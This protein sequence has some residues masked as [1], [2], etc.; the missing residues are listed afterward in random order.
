MSTTEDH[1]LTSSFF[2][3]TAGL[4]GKGALIPLRRLVDA[5]CQRKMTL[6]VKGQ[7]PL[8]YHGRSQVRR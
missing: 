5:F 8:R 2:S 6:T 3:S 1:P 7:K 4:L